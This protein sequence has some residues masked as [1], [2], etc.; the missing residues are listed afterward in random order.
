MPLNKF[1]DYV[2]GTMGCFFNVTCPYLFRATEVEAYEYGLYTM[3][4]II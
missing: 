3:V 1:P 4:Y 2:D